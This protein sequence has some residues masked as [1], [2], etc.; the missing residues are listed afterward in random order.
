MKANK[1]P[2]RVYYSHLHNS[3]FTTI[4]YRETHLGKLYTVQQS[5]CKA[6]YAYISLTEPRRNRSEG[7]SKFGAP[8]SQRHDSVVT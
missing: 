3:V 2:F 1:N 8:V 6:Y 4:R 5:E 7:E